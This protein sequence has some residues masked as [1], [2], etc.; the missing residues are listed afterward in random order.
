MVL[1]FP[2]AGWMPLYYKALA[3]FG[4]FEKEKLRSACSSK[5]NAIFPT[6]IHQTWPEPFSG[7]LYSDMRPVLKGVLASGTGQHFQHKRSECYV[8]ANLF[9]LASNALKRIKSSLQNLT[10][11]VSLSHLRTMLPESSYRPL[12]A[13]RTNHAT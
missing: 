12:P 5:K 13:R 7:A 9:L 1:A 6:Q 2:A 4:E 3:R 10:I 11:T 8:H